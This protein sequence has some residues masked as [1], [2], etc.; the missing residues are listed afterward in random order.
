MSTEKAETNPGGDYYGDAQP[1]QHGRQGHLCCGC[2]CDV[3]QRSFDRT[4]FI[5]LV[6]GLNLKDCFRNAFSTWYRLA[7]QLSS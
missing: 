2:C 5:F 1:A 6:A 7:E 4:A 3:S